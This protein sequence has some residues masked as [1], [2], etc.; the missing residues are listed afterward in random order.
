MLEGKGSSKPEINNRSDDDVFN[1]KAKCHRK[2]GGGKINSQM[3]D[4]VTCMSEALLDHLGVRYKPDRLVN[5]Y[6]S[7]TA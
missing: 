1:L 2:H 6:E 3:W 5:T 4:D 7:R